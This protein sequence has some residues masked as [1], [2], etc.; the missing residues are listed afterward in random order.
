MYEICWKFHM[1]SFGPTR[2]V[3]ERVEH[4]DIKGPPT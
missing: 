4:P 3:I 2:S 1:K